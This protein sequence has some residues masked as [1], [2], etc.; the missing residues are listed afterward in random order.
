MNQF[1]GRTVRCNQIGRQAKQNLRWESFSS[2]R[3]NDFF[4]E[5]GV[6]HNLYINRII[7]DWNNMSSKI[8]SDPSINSFKARLDMK[9]KNGCYSS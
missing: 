2:K 4:R 7:P 5:V 6:R 1:V 3:S 8:V 9:Y